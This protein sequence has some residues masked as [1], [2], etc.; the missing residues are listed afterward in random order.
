MVTMH[1]THIKQAP[2]RLGEQA[3]KE[4]ALSGCKNHG[5]EEGS[6]QGR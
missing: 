6:V 1:V 5:P 3:T 2:D 4:S